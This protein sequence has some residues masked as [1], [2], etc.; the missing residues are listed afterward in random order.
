MRKSKAGTDWA[1]AKLQYVSTD[2]TLLE[3]SKQLK[4][5][6]HTVRRQSR[7]DKWVEQRTAFNAEVA[8]KSQAVQAQSRVQKL[9][10]WNESDF[11]I[12]AALRSQVARQ[13][14]KFA[15]VQQ[16]EEFDPPLSEIQRMS[17]I[18]ESSQRIARLSLGATTDNQGNIND[19][20]EQGTSKPRLSDF[21]DSI[22]FEGPSASTAPVEKDD[23]SDPAA[24]PA[25]VH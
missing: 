12:A 18:I 13:L 25:A 8:R 19:P 3:L 23:A 4:V 21:Y 5:H 17:Q 11:R 6:E 14:N 2:I 24:P 16:E 9:K 15:K 20:D 7:I 10:E 1:A 22:Q